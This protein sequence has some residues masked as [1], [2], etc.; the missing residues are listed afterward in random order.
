M[1]ERLLFIGS[2][3]FIGFFFFSILISSCLNTKKV[4]YFQDL[5]DT[6][7]IYSQVIN[8]TYES[9]I[10]PDDIIGISVSSI[11]P[12][13]TAV[14]NMQNNVSQLTPDAETGNAINTNV[15][16]AAAKGYLVDKQGL[17][18]FPVIG[19]LKVEGLTTSQLKDSFK[20]RLNQYLQDPIVNV[21]LL[22]YKITVL[23]EVAKPSTY[24]ISSERITAIDAIG[25]A[26]DLTLY[27]MRENVLLIREENGIRKFVRLNLNSSDFFE[28]PYFYLKQNDIIYVEPNKAKVAALESPSLRRISFIASLISLALLAFIRLR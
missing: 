14:F 11:N 28:S 3:R 4:A 13:A 8:G 22:N 9:H 1:N 6:S 16:G 2:L 17:I 15:S 19:K 24:S 10:Q 5:K 25:M 7:K 27:G 12:Q 23:G 18:D 26:G 21:R 20:T